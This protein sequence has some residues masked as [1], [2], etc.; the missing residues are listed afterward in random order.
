MGIKDRYPWIELDVGDMAVKCTHC[1]SRLMLS[2][3]AAR[4][5]AQLEAFVAEHGELVCVP[6][7]R[8]E[9]RP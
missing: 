3:P 1:G 5:V 7:A 8:Q 9:S 6:A 2:Y 4:A